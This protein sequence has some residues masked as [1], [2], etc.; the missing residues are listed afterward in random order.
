MIPLPLEDLQHVLTHAPLAELRKA[1][2]FVTGGT[3]FFGKWLLETLLYANRELSLGLQVTVLSRNPRRFAQSVPYLAHIPEVTMVQGNVIEG[4][5]LDKPYDFII[6]AAT[7]DR[8][9]PEDLD[10]LMMLDTTILGTR[11]VLELARRSRCRGI[12]FTS[13]GAIYGHQPAEVSHLS[14]EHPCRSEPLDP[15]NTYACGKI[16]AEQL[17]VSYSQK[18]QIPVKIARCFTFAGPY[19]PLDLHYAFGD[20]IND[21]L[22]GGP[23]RVNGDGAPCRSYLYAAD[24]A[25]W[26]WTILLRAP[27]ARPYNVGSE[28]AIT[29]GQLAQKIAGMHNTSCAIAR[30]PAPGAAPNQYV[31]STARARQELHLTQ[32]IS[33]EETIRRT[34]RWIRSAQD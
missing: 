20:F 12:L 18:F 2:L 24:L 3:G 26:L 19:L 7:I 22:A 4:E 29:V 6:H 17:C 31:P 33:L 13:S 25:V 32:R 27:V 21:A 10:P 28:E 9:R 16:I 11:S 30:D 34:L 15:R 1:R 8:A 23:V 14:E 5:Y